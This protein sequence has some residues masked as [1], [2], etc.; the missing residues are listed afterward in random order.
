MAPI[1]AEARWYH[2]YYGHGFGHFR[3]VEFS[4]QGVAI[5]AGII[6]AIV[7]AALTE[8]RRQGRNRSRSRQYGPGRSAASGSGRVRIRTQSPSLLGRWHLWMPLVA[9]FGAAGITCLASTDALSLH[10]SYRPGCNIKGNINDRGEYIYHMPGQKY[11]SRTVIST[12]RG[13]RWFC[14]EEE[15]QAAGWRRAKMVD[16]VD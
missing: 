3:T 5:A 10:L 8:N 7:F 6:A 15:A 13:E 4:W 16:G 11:Y 14:S 2:H 1:D 12:S 9:F